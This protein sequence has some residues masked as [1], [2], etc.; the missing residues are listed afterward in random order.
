[1]SVHGEVWEISPTVLRQL[2]RLEGHPD[3]YRRESI[4]VQINSEAHMEVQAYLRPARRR[5]LTDQLRT[6]VSSFFLCSRDTA[7]YGWAEVL[8][9]INPINRKHRRIPC[10][11]LLPPITERSIGR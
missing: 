4:Q 6:G 5:M 8:C 10:S 2:D 7:A 3:W 1:M 9:L 11:K